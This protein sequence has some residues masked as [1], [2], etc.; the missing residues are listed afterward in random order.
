MESSILLLLFFLVVC[1]SFLGCIIVYQY[2]TIK[3]LR[4]INCDQDKEIDLLYLERE[5]FTKK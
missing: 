4:T 3:E 2:F 5:N 1:I